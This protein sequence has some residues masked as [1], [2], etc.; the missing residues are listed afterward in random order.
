MTDVLSVIMRWLHIT[1]AVVVVGG[2]L[3]A[4]F[5]IAPALAT[6][7]A[8]EQDNL[9]AAM[10]ARYRSL[11]YL[12]VV[13]LA[14]TGLYNTIMNMGRGPLYQSLLGIKLLLVLHVFAVGLLIVKPKN[15]KRSRQM[16]GLVISGL[17]IIAI[18]A[19]LR[20]LHLN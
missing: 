15:P 10:A 6:L 14:G 8:Q 18:S 1:S 5:V 20:Q 2:V 11:L 16:T 7:A 19:V 12:A 9:G 17:V 3:Y 13:L 4:R